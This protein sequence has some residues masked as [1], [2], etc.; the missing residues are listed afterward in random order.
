MS[1]KNI[2]NIKVSKIVL[3]ITKRIESFFNYYKYSKSSRKKDS[4]FWNTPLDKK[5]FIFSGIIFIV[6]TYYLLPSFYNKNLVK[7][8]LKD[9]ILKKYN[10]EVKLDKDLR[11]GLFPKP[12][13]LIEEGKIIYDTKTIS[14]SK[15][16]KF[17][18]SSKK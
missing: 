3:S 9:Q 16:I 13:F 4:N 1:K 10:L 14:V 6:I 2:F 5:I 8:Q 18:I 11:Y 17:F 15:N 12:H 7:N